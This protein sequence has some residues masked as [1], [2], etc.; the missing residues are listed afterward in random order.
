MG[1]MRNIVA[2]QY[3]QIDVETI[4]ETIQ[5][6]LPLLIPQLQALLNIEVQD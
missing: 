1:D 4:W 5:Q 2:H 3:F 6:D